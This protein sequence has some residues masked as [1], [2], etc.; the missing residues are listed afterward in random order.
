MKIITKIKLR[1]IP[2][3][4]YVRLV[5]SRVESFEESLKLME[6][7]VKKP[8][9]FIDGIMFA[10]NRG[11]IMEGRFSE[12]IDLPVSTFN[13]AMDEWFYLHAEK[14]TKKNNE[15]MEG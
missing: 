11:V 5:Y 4:K 6:G 2:V 9:D 3:K 8:V 14:V 15:Y 1:L 12:K 10:K 13:K 7:L